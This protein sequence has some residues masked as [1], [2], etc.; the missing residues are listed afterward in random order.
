MKFIVS[1][2]T[3]LQHLQSIA[4]VINTNNTL[5]I[6]EN[7]LF[8]IDNK[9][10]FLKSTDLDCTMI[11]SLD[12]ES[13]ES[14]S[15][16]IDAK[17]ILDFL[18][19][20]P[21]QPL[22]FLTN[23]E[24]NTVKVVSEDG[25]YSFSFF[26]GSEFPKTPTLDQKKEIK[27]DAKVF[28]NSISQT[29]FATGNDELRPVMSGV[30]C[31][32]SSEDIKF[33]ATDAHKLIKHTTNNQ[34]KEIASFIL[35]KKPLSIIKN[36]ISDSNQEININYD[37]SNAIFSF[38]NIII[39]CRLID[40]K[41]PDYEAVIPKDNPH[42]LTINK[43][44]LVGALKKVMP[45]SNKSTNQVVLDIKGNAI[46]VSS[47]DIDIN[48]NAMS[49]I[50]TGLSYK[51]EDIKIAFNGKFL[52][53]ILHSLNYEELKIKLSTP[54]KAITIEPTDS[55]NKILALIMPIMIAEN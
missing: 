50:K 38:D 28:L 21:E 26:D 55:K 49:G 44:L 40:G 4:G 35:P 19:A 37:I 2:E 53:E 54:A 11:T 48:N 27:I 34:S 8:E 22:T 15:I 23:N 39:Y 36:I 31:D 18:K 10:L 12:I 25:E 24:N 32:I 46:Q 42:E 30:F 20:F 1:S 7:F 6:L 13:E 9:K 47:I 45:L 16:A 41:Y 5:P 3:L 51:G 29:I 14:G 33:V 43:E 52:L 17:M